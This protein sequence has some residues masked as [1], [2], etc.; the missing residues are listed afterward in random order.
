VPQV[1]GTFSDGAASFLGIPSSTEAAVYCVQGS[2]AW[3]KVREELERSVATLPAGA[4]FGV[5][6]FD[7]EPRRFKTSLVAQTRENREALAKWLDKLEPDHGADPYAGLL[8]ALDLAAGRG[9]VPAAD[10]IFLLALTKPPDGTLFEDPRQVGQEI[11]AR[12]ELL[13]IRIHCVGPSDGVHSYY[14]QH[15]ANQWGGLHVNG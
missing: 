5:V 15:L 4:A 7:S 14:L 9:K 6:V 11:R 3:E 13:G 12:N 1:T 8:A 10:T 2:A